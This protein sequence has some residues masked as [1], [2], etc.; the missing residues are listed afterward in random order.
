MGSR[1]VSVV[2]CLLALFVACGGKSG[3][4]PGAVGGDAGSGGT[5]SMGEGATGNAAGGSAGEPSAAAGTGVAEGGSET[6]SAGAGPA[7]G[8]AGGAAPDEAPTFCDQQPHLFCADFDGEAYDA[9]WLSQDA[10]GGGNMGSTTTQVMSPPRALVSQIE[11]QVNVKP[12]SATLSVGFPAGAGGFALQFDL[13]VAELTPDPIYPNQTW[14]SLFRMVNGDSDVGLSITF[15]QQNGDAIW[16][17]QGNGISGHSLFEQIPVQ[18]W[19]HVE[20]TVTYDVLGMGSYLLRLGHAPEVMWMNTTVGDAP[21]PLQ[22][23][24]GL[25]TNVAGS[26]VHALYDNVTLD[27]LP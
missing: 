2:W 5:M 1:R 13:F 4:Q 18:T 27:L 17:Q 23:H 24:L 11:S 12:A 8:G 19:I 22:L 7:E 3:K 15:D 16:W 6:P 20:V 25:E 10:M 14:I 21:G 9:G 26:T